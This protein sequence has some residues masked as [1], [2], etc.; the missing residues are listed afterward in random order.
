M[1]EN[2]ICM[3]PARIG[4]KRLQRKNLLPLAGKPMLGY[5]IEAA[6]EA[7]CT[8]VYV[9]TESE[10]IADLARQIGAEVPFLVP[11]E[12]CGDFISSHEPCQ[13]VAEK[14]NPGK[15]KTDVML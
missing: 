4:S 9:C 13:F 7:G 11:E 1:P 14:I 3:I 6:R 10:E 12:L 2:I 8:P 15:R 5:S